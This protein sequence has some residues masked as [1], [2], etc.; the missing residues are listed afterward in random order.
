MKRSELETMLGKQ[1]EILLDNGEQR[2][3]VLYKTD[4]LNYFYCDTFIREDAFL[5]SHVKKAE[6]D[7]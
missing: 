5:C 7:E 2:K 4:F 6:V 3:G 1:V